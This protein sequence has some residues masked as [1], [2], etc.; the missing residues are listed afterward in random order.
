MISSFWVSTSLILILHPPPRTEAGS[1]SGDETLLKGRGGNQVYRLIALTMRQGKR[2][3]LGV[4]RSGCKSCS[5]PYLWSVCIVGFE[6]RA[7]SNQ[8]ICGEFNKR[9]IQKARAKFKE[10][11]E[12]CSIWGYW[13]VI[14]SGPERE[15]VGSH[16]WKAEGQLEMNCVWLEG[17]GSFTEIN[18]KG[19]LSVAFPSPTSVSHWLSPMRSQKP[20]E[21]LLQA[22]SFPGTEGRGGEGREGRRMGLEWQT[23]DTQHKTHRK[24]Q[25]FR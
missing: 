10:N 5:C 23:K 19:L 21:S 18:A 20:R 3:G 2:P 13:H 11:S 17:Y 24:T 6:Q 1:V 16:V 7:C 8:V 22:D 15:G 14:T 4:H 9:T 12:Q 25:E